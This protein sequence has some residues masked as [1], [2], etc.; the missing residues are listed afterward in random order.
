MATNNYL[1]SLIAR[2]AYCTFLSATY[3]TYGDDK[4]TAVTTALENTGIY[5]FYTD[6]N[7]V[8]AK[9][10]TAVYKVIY[11]YNDPFSGFSGTVFQDKN[12][13]GYTIAFRGTE[14]APG[15]YTDLLDLIADINLGWNGKAYLQLISLQ[16]FINNLYTADGANLSIG[17]LFDVIGDSLGG[18][19]AEAF[20]ANKFSSVNQAVIFEAPG[21]AQSYLIEHGIS[22]SL[23]ASKIQHVYGD[24]GLE[25][26][27]GNTWTGTAFA[28]SS[29]V[30]PQNI[31]PIFIE[32]RWSPLNASF[33]LNHN[34]SLNNTSLAV[35]DLFW[36]IQPNLNINIITKILEASSNNPESSM[37]NI[38][39]ALQK[40]Y[41]DPTKPTPKPLSP[42]E[43]YN[44]TIFNAIAEL[45]TL[46]KPYSVES[47]TDQASQAIF[48]KAQ[49]NTSDGLA[50]RYA[51]KELNPFVVIGADYSQHNTNGELDLY[52]PATGQGQ[53]TQQWLTDRAKFL[54]IY[55]DN[56][57]GLTH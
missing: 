16:T 57:I 50:Y 8:M 55:L 48:T 37:E 26:I 22:E 20:V 6:V 9:D 52:N 5:P 28:G 13:G 41:V 34:L 27:T 15:T 14:F 32:N 44:I 1:Q 56:N 7:H 23:W 54:A 24:A 30:T 19:L 4:K 35:Y 10:F 17:A 40:I 36:K 3:A 45:R 12:T 39:N 18:Y 2:A 46:I 33:S 53:L 42:I 51:L 25:I 47:L 11:Q 49:E 31:Q 29:M 38:L 43:K 21:I